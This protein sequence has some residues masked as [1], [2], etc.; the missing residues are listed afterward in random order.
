MT[1]RVVAFLPS[2]SAQVPPRRSALS[3]SST[4]FFYNNLHMTCLKVGLVF[5]DNLC[6]T[7]PIPPPHNLASAAMTVALLQSMLSQRG[8]WIVSLAAWA[9]GGGLELLEDL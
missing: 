5:M 9:H 4:Y 1:F 6:I 7:P 2:F 3:P 8:L